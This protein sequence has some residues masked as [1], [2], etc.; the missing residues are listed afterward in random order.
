FSGAYWQYLNKAQLLSNEV[1]YTLSSGAGTK[2]IYFQI[3]DGSPKAPV[4]I[5]NIVNSSI[6]L[7]AVKDETVKEESTNEKI[8]NEEETISKEDANGGTTD[9]D[10]GDTSGDSLSL[11]QADLSVQARRITENGQVAYQVSVINNGP[12]RMNSGV[13]KFSKMINGSYSEQNRITISGLANG[14]TYSEVFQIDN[15]NSAAYKFDVWIENG[16]DS[17]RSNNSQVVQYLTDEASETVSENI[18]END[19]QRIEN[20]TDLEL[21]S[22][23]LPES[24]IITG[25]NNR[26]GAVIR[27]NG[28]EFVSDRSAKVHLTIG[29]F[30]SSYEVVGRFESGES[31][32]VQLTNLWTP[33]AT[34][35]YQVNYSIEIAG[36]DAG[37]PDTNARNNAKTANIEVINPTLYP[38]VRNVNLIGIPE[39]NNIAQTGDQNIVT[40]EVSNL[41]P[42]T[43]KNSITFGFAVS[44]SPEDTEESVWSRNRSVTLR[45]GETQV[46]SFENVYLPVGGNYNLTAQADFPNTVT[47]NDPRAVVATNNVVVQQSIADLRIVSFEPSQNGINQNRETEIIINFI[48]DGPNVAEHVKLYLKT[49]TGAAHPFEANSVYIGRVEPGQSIRHAIPKIY[50]TEPGRHGFMA[51]VKNLDISVDDPGD[52]PN[53]NNRQIRYI[54]VQG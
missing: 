39:N 7:E 16:N 31:K 51:K 29:N 10:T 40:V 44:L 43:N 20:G 49:T 8:L 25:I 1:N 50:I 37:M 15:Q 30:T 9:S 11:P 12:D 28:P 18:A 21:V 46:I 47:L 6:V 38:Q 35:S 5:S 48:N 2:T 34:G 52:G 42:D 23:E 27:N 32:T 22:I 19:R 53:G 33:G 14:A 24:D 41:E 36:Q 13:L 45:P 54:D 3:A 4:S 17:N 26:I